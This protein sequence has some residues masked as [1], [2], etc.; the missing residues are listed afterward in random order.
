MYKLFVYGTLKS[1]SVQR[2]LLGHILNSYYAEL[3]GYSINTAE[4]YY[5]VVPNENGCVKGKILLLD[6]V[7]FLYIDQWE[8]T[9]LY[10]KEEVTVES[11]NGR[12]KVYIYIKKD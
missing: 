3:K 9:P 10:L 4:E 5:N 8:E 1:E 6:K 2:K 7:D 11:H 12:E